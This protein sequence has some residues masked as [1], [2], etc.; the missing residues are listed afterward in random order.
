MNYP[1]TELAFYNWV[2]RHFTEY[3]LK[4]EWSCDEKKNGFVKDAVEE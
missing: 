2:S 1:F 3:N 4:S